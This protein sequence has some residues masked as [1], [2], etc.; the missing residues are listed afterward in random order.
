MAIPKNQVRTRR[1]LIPG[2]NVHNNAVEDIIQKTA[3]WKNDNMQRNWLQN[4]EIGHNMDKK[5]EGHTRFHFINPNGLSLAREGLEFN[6]LCNTI[7][8]HDIDHMGLM[9]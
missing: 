1:R 9:E 8:E 6:M 3:S 4:T 5:I 2:K 7:L